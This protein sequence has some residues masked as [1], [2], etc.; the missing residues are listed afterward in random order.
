M[1]V[2]GAAAD[3]GNRRAGGVLTC[4]N[5]N[6]DSESWVV[7]DYAVWAVW[8][9]FYVALPNGRVGSYAVVGALSLYLDFINR[10]F[11]I[12]RLVGGRRD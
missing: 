6:A 9:V 12:L 1:D 2:S 11:F 3:G 10:F 4:V 8:T 5:R 7:L